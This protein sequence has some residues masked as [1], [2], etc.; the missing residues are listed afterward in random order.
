MKT[1]SVDLGE[2]SYPI[3][4]EENSLTHI[5][6]F[7]AKHYTGKRAAIITDSIVKNYLN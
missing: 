1:V 3:Y 6:D 4:V 5:G 7:L 2:R